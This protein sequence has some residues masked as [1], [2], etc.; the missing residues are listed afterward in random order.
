MLYQSVVVSG[1]ELG[2]PIGGT[3]VDVDEVMAADFGQ[4]DLVRPV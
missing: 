2:V 4:W 3:H 1:S